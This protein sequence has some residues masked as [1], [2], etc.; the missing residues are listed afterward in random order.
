MPLSLLVDAGLSTDLRMNAH[1]FVGL[2]LALIWTNGAQSLHRLAAMKDVKCDD[3]VP[4]RPLNLTAMSGYWYE[5]GRAPKVSV[6]KCLNVSVPAT[7]DIKLKLKLEYISTIADEINAVKETISFPWDDLTK[8]SIFVLNYGD[9]S[10]FPIS[11]TYKVVYSDP[12]L[13]TVLC[14]YSSMSPMP[15][16]KILSRQRQLSSDNNHRNVAMLQCVRPQKRLQCS[17]C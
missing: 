15:L 13:L 8:N 1:L 7:A 5:A 4:G 3:S 17:P 10:K 2:L 6:L 14:G 12:Q 16:V 11:V 9:A